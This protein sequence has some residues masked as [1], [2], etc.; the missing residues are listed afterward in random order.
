MNKK[1]TG[2]LLL[3]FPFW[4]WAQS[5]LTANDAVR[6]ALQNNFDVLIAK[7]QSEANAILNTAG[8]AGML[9]TVALYATVGTNQNNI[10][11]KYS[12]GNEIN[13]NGVTGSAINPGIALQWTLFDG[14]KMFITKNKL[15]E[16]EN[17]GIIQYQEQILNTT[18]SILL[19]YYDVVRQQMQLQ[20]TLEVIAYNEERVKITEGRLNTGLGPKTDFLQAKI[21]LNIQKENKLNYEYQLADAKRKLNNLIGR[22]ISTD[23]K[24]EDSILLQPLE[25]RD[26][27]EAKMLQSNPTLMDFQAQLKISKF[28]LLET[29]TSF[30]PKLVLNSGYNFNRTQNSAGFSL[31]NQSYGWQTNLVLSMPLYQAGKLKH[32]SQI[33]QLNIQTLQQQL[34]QAKLAANLALQSALSMYDVRQK[35]YDL[36]K[37]NEELARENM[38][39]SLKRLQL[40]LGTA[41]DVSQAQAT[42]SSSVFRMASFLFDLKSSE[43]NARKQAADF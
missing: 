30:L 28:S 34:S 42:F 43:L 27:L 6:L 33:A 32:A 37:E 14:T 26:K 11:Q 23:Y 9:P 15:N 36:E 24:V 5:L 25:N 7:N 8:E 20:A 41:L 4:G 39:L 2:C 1:L 16:I 17:L 10:Q 19:A 31:Y 18:L 40:G 29:K 3:L 22:N 12:N 38:V 35:A 21:D 13:Q